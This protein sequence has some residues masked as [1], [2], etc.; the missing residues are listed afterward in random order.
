MYRRQSKGWLK[1]I[2]FIILDVVCL[3][4]S[5]V[6]AYFIRN[7]IE[8][9]YD[10]QIY[11]NMAVIIA[12]IDIIILVFYETFKGI[13]RRG[14]YREFVVT[15]KQTC[16][17]ELIT[18]FYMFSLQSSS[19]FSR[20]I[21]YLTG[22]F[23]LVLA[24]LTRIIWKSCLKKQLNYQGKR[25]L[26][27]ITCDSMV[28][29]VV[30]SIAEQKFISYRIAGIAV[31]N[32][33]MTGQVIDGVRIVSNRENV[34]EYV[35]REWVDEIFV[36][37]PTEE[38][39]PDQLMEE[40]NEMGIVVHMK[41]AKSGEFLGQTKL[42]ESL[43]GYTVLTSSINS[44]SMGQVFMKRLLDIIGGICGCVV[45]GIL[46]LI[47]APMIYSKSPGPIFF[48]QVRV[49]RNGKRF[50]IYKFRSM[51]MDAEERKAELMEDNRVKDGMMFKLEW[52]PRIIGCEKRPDG[53]TKKG[54]GNYI[55]D[56]SLDEFPQFFNVLK[57]DM[58]LVGTRPPTLDEWN[59][60]ELRHR[61][62]LSIKPGITGMWQT[63]GRSNV[64][65]FEKVVE[66]DREYIAS[67]SFG[68][69]IK[70]LLKTVQAVVK[71]DGS[72]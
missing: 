55:R 9:L 66:M 16:L 65:D 58:S 51:Y 34:A 1:H 52:D 26:L 61:A 38:P 2:D 49:G 18:T 7:G 69:D 64:V 59:R 33:D 30:Q 71:R 36:N 17:V 54:I 45:T 25:S 50:K 41:L 21:M 11:R 29:N 67:W 63:N 42:V 6:I 47:L 13:L 56:W 3:Q 15:V 68:L 14:L 72:M 53:T 57:G 12:L 4:L 22:V 39:Y 8:N 70:I 27:I 23:Y 37:L 24:Y 5:F 48:S 31:V 19:D 40:F 20:V 28:D 43:G 35:C 10:V 32:R 60:Y 44:A 62:R 46:F